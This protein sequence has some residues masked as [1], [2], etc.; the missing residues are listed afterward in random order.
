VVLTNDPHP[1]SDVKK[2]VVVED[3]VVI[4]TMSVVLPG[5]VV[6]KDTLVGAHSLVS[7]NTNE[8]T[9]VAGSPAKEICLASKICLKDGSHQSAYPWRK[10]FHRGYPVD[11]VND[12][13]TEF[14]I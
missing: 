8:G 5:V 4:S 14:E 13:K 11:V 1:P 12:W 7:K 10:H 6:R 9:L 3:Y 2:G